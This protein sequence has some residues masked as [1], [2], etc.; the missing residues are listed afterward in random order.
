M[1]P[2]LKKTAPVAVL[3]EWT[4]PGWIYQG[5]RREQVPWPWPWRT[6]RIVMCNVQWGAVILPFF[7]ILRY[8]H[9]SL[10]P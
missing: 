10:T 5:Y 4:G 2:N 1:P 3:K 8:N 9:P 7:H 6:E